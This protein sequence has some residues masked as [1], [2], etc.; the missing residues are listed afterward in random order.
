[1]I[2]G[3]AELNTRF[4]RRMSD[5]GYVVR[6]WKLQAA[7]HEGRVA[8][9]PYFAV[10]FQPFETCDQMLDKAGAAELEL[11]NRMTRESSKK[12]DTYLL[13]ASQDPVTDSDQADRIVGLEYD[14]RH[15]RKLVAWDCGQRP[16]AMEDL[17]RP[18]L[19]LARIEV[20]A[21]TR[22]P[23]AALGDRLVARSVNPDLVQRALS[24]YREGLP[25]G[26]L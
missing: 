15:M 9:N 21:S 6:P 19:E 4:E 24:M 18:F 22:D 1:M 12:W 14:T 13:L 26:A 25:L 23:L 2:S 7:D 10:A 8:E 5:A 3:L 17:V 20:R 11:T 16:A